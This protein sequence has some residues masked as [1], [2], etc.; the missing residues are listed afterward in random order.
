MDEGFIL[1]HDLR[2]SSIVGNR[3]WQSLYLD[4]QG[5][6]RDWPESGVRL[7]PPWPTASVPHHLAKPYI[8]EVPRPSRTVLNHL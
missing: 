4:G 3:L 6:E 5:I 2:R 1:A 8:P 7:E